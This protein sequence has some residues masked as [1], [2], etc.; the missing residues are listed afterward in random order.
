MENPLARPRWQAI[1]EDVFAPAV[2]ATGER[3]LALIMRGGHGEL[4]L[5]AREGN[6]WGE[7]RS[8]GVPL[9]RSDGS[10]ALIPVEW[11]ISACATG[12]AEVQLVARGPE[13]ELLR[14]ILRGGASGGFEC[15]GFPA[16]GG[17]PMG[18]AGAPSACSRAPGR[19]D[20]FA[21]GAAGALLHTTWD[22]EAFGEFESLG[23]LGPRGEAPIAGPISACNC[24]S[25]MAV[26]TRGAP[27]DLLLKWWNGSSWSAFESL[28]APR[29]PD[30]LYPAVGVLVPLS[31]AP[32]ACGGGSTRLDVFARG[33]RG[34]LLHKLWDG[35]TWS[36]F[37]SLGMA[38]SASSDAWIPF[39]GASLACAWEKYRLD[40]FARALDGRLYTAS[41]SG[42][43]D[44]PALSP[45]ASPQ[46]D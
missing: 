22:G 30:S 6:S 12:P 35:K 28:G 1:S 33:P 9:A 8:L 43:W 29:E 25:A 2:A 34:D 17:L 38:R 46:L 19:M 37:E 44:D 15:V 36:A 41:L 14:A 10:S 27:G 18:L 32:V 3:S 4:L 13:G 7:P 40:V 23:G 11:P 5:R 39:T 21:V 20:V 45:D 31:S 16:A 24:G 42:S 26:F